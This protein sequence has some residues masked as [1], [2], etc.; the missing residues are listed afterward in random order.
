[1]ARYKQ[2]FEAARRQKRCVFIPFFIIGYPDIAT[3]YKIIKTA[4]DAGADALELGIPFSDPIADG[5]V[6]SAACAQAISRGMNIEKA[7][8]IIRKIRGTTQIPIGLLMYAQMVSCYGIKKFYAHAAA[9]GV[10]SILIADMP[11]EE[12]GLALREGE[13]YRISQIFMAA[14]TTP[15]HRIR[16]LSNQSPE[17]L[18]LVSILGVTGV[19]K[20]FS[21]DTI[22]FVRKTREA[23]SIPLVVGFG[24]S[25]PQQAQQIA[26]AGAD[27][28]IVGSAL[29][30]IIAKHQ[31]NPHRLFGEIASFVTRM[32]KII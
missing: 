19:Q 31:K 15:P 24:I 8:E 16:K 22:G 18:Y 3:S 25:A 11:L 30:H 5:P 32:K 14:Q 17:F 23:S 10:D 9:A 27:G 21:Q 1:M 4:I 7:F 6:I 2:T 12:S 13:K 28:I 26:D 20:K 29:V